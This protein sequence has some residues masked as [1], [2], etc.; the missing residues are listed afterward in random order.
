M[1]LTT[2][3]GDEDPEQPAD[4]PEVVL[5]AVEVTDDLAGQHAHRDRHDRRQDREDH[6]APR[7][8][9]RPPGSPQAEDGTKAC[10]DDGADGSSATQA[11]P[12]VPAVPD[13]ED[14]AAGFGPGGH[15]APSS[16]KRSSS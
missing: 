2:S 8:D 13:V 12:V 11:W 3:S 4:L 15:A 16:R 7:N 14:R 5:V 9:L 10:L 6:H 1:S